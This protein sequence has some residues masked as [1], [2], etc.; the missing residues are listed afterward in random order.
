MYNIPPPPLLLLSKIVRFI[1]PNGSTLAIPTY[2]IQ[3]SPKHICKFSLNIFSSF[4]I[5]SI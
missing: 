3:P 2:L 1:N 5:N 4:L